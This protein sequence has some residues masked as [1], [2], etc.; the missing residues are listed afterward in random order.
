MT[1]Q[2]TLDALGG[3]Y[4]IRDS[5]FTEDVFDGSCAH[6]IFSGVSFI[7]CRFAGADFSSSEFSNC[8]FMG[9]DLS[10]GTFA[11]GFFSHVRFEGTKAVGADF[12][13]CVLRDVTVTDTAFRFANF[14][15]T[16]WDHVAVRESSFAEASLTAVTPRHVTFTDCDL[17]RAELFRTPLRGI[18]LRTDIL[19]GITVS[20]FFWELRGAIVDE[21]QAVDLARFLGVEIQ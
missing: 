3:G 15:G 5:V 20:D 11:E 17:T 8:R 4:E 9:C 21:M 7:R 1:F 16:K 19:R 18:D 12:T 14:G 6:R 10:N 2:E 13:R